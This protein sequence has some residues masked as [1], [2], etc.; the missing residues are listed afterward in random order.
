MS[1]LTN[2]DPFFQDIGAWDTSGVT[3]MGPDVLPRA[4]FDQDL[5]W[6]FD[7]GVKMSSAF[8]GTPCE[9]TSC[10]VQV[11]PARRRPRRRRLADASR[12]RRA[13]DASAATPAPTTPAFCLAPT[14][15]PTTPAPTRAPTTPAPTRAPTTPV[16]TPGPW[17][18]TAPGRS[19]RASSRRRH[20]R[21]TARLCARPRPTRRRLPADCGRRGPRVELRVRE[22]LEGQDALAP[23]RRADAV[24]R[25]RVQRQQQLSRRNAVLGLGGH[26]SAPPPRCAMTA[27][28]AAA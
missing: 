17:A 3:S 21:A 16:P 19:S 10:G 11:A 1:M 22:G 25:A 8:Y 15:A 9:S 4:A 18:A 7:D 24:R 5:G 14:R 28:R 13:D 20:G 23:A 26:A 2:A 27:S 6:C 12:R